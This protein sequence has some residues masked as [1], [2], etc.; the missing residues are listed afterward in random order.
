MEYL[1]ASGIHACMPLIRLASSIYISVSQQGQVYIYLVGDKY[2]TNTCR[3]CAA[4]LT[5]LGV[6]WWPNSKEHTTLYAFHGN[7]W[8]FVCMVKHEYRHN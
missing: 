5:A 2:G 7:V 1:G 6:K 4:V 3:S 8:S